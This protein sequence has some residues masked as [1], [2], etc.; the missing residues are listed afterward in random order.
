[1]SAPTDTKAPALT[2]ED[3]FESVL[4]AAAR[5]GADARVMFVDRSQLPGRLW[6]RAKGATFWP[7]DGGRTEVWIDARLRR[8]VQG[9]LDIL[10]HELA[11]VIAGPDDEHGPKWRRAYAAIHETCCEVPAITREATP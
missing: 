1:M 5:M 3:P 2:F 6:W 8:G 11:H 9:T 7:D 4:V 10:A